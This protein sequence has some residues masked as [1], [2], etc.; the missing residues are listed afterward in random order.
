MLLHQ[1]RQEISILAQMRHAP[2]TLA[3][4]RGRL[5]A[6][7]L[8]RI[9]RHLYYQE[10]SKTL[11]IIV[12]SYTVIYSLH[13]IALPS[14][15][16]RESRILR[17]SRAISTLFNR[18]VALCSLCSTSCSCWL[19]CTSRL[20]NC[21]FVSAVSMASPDVSGASDCRTISLAIALDRMMSSC[22]AFAVRTQVLTSSFVS[23][24][25][26]CISDYF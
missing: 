10:H 20:R 8:G 6:S 4:T 2:R 5:A 17:S 23:S 18:V 7:L 26:I 19:Y 11:F 14:K 9:L 15:S 13:T 21:T 12:S 24:L 16:L 25:I 1:P 22:S 3:Q